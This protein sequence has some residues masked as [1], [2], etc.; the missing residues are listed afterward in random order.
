MNILPW[1]RVLSVELFDSKSLMRFAYCD[2]NR[3][4]CTLC[5]DLQ[6]TPALSFGERLKEEQGSILLTAIRKSDE[7]LKILI[8]THLGNA[9]FKETGPYILNVTIRL[10][11]NRGKQLLHLLTTEY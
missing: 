6:P 7:W 5:E 9:S 2:T 8:K 11:P 4:Y 3:C 10:K 1:K